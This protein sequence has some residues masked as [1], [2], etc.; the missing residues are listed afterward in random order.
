MSTESGADALSQGTASPDLNNDASGGATDTSASSG[1]DDRVV[2]LEKRVNG[3]SAVLSR[4]EKMI[5][6]LSA[7]LEEAQSAQAKP[8]EEKEDSNGRNADLEAAKQEIAQMRAEIEAKERANNE[9]TRKHLGIA[10]FQSKGLGA[11]AA[12]EAYISM[13]AHE[14]SKISLS[15]DESTLIYTKSEFDDPVP[16]SNFV[17]SFLGSE[18]GSIYAPKKQNPNASGRANGVDSSGRKYVTAAE[19]NS[20]STEQLKSGQFVLKG[21]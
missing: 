3:Q 1:H 6:S 18:R 8:A 11:I 7:K 20:L 17:E 16:I 13:M 4:M 15:Q 10:E 5:G 19:M 14:G 2:G 21:D 12:E 9:R